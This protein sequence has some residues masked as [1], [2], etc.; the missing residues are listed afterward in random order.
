MQTKK[1]EIR[2]AILAQAQRE[3]M[4]KGFQKAS[5]RAIATKANITHSNIYHYFKSKDEL[6]VAIM[7]PVL[8]A[9]DAGMNRMLE[10]EKSEEHNDLMDHLV[11]IEGPSHFICN[12][13]ELLKLLAFKA[14]G[15]SLAN[16]H[17]TLTDILTQGYHVVMEGMAR[18]HNLGEI[19]VSEFFLHNVAAIWVNFAIEA[20]MHDIAV[21]EMIDSATRMMTFIYHGWCGIIE[22]A[23]GEQ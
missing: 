4:A 10:H 15:S 2:D 13:R 3:F 1:D 5:L 7:Q 8:D 23:G 19:N 18:R 20:L 16:Y 11:F 6:F 17:E 14:A 12:H 21:E 22:M 9:I